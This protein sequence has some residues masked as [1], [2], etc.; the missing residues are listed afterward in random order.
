[1]PSEGGTVVERQRTGSTQFRQVQ[2]AR[3]R[4]RAARRCF[5]AERRRRSGARRRRAR[6]WSATNAALRWRVQEARQPAHVAQRSPARARYSLSQEGRRR[7]IA[8]TPRRHAAGAQ[9]PPGASRLHAAGVR[10]PLKREVFASP[11]QF[12]VT[13][14]PSALVLRA[15]CAAASLARSGLFYACRPPW[16]QRRWQ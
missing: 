9:Q 4:K 7:Q 1:M 10:Q 2:T 15:S 3:S 8:K 12:A 13:A 6:R 16:R 11:A 14:P 5:A